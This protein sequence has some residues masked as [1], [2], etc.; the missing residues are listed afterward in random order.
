MFD[1]DPPIFVDRLC[2]GGATE[3]HDGPCAWLVDA[4]AAM[5]NPTYPIR[6]LSRHQHVMRPASPCCRIRRE[7]GGAHPESL[8]HGMV[9]VGCSYTYEST[10]SGSAWVSTVV[11]VHCELALITSRQR[12]DT[13]VC[14]RYCTCE[15][16]PLV[17]YF[18]Q[19]THGS[20]R[21]HR[22]MGRLVQRRQSSR[23]EGGSE[24]QHQPAPPAH[25]PVATLT[26]HEAICIPLHCN[27]NCN[28]S[29]SFTTA[30]TCAVL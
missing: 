6:T 29:G 5:C 22:V 16:R 20:K 13:G 26:H 7:H 3:M 28:C 12:R 15:R 23:L 30:A 27:R 10:R 17:T 25:A 8:A 4:T 14:E 24:C 21:R 9:K 18:T 1:P 2:R 11:G 19:R